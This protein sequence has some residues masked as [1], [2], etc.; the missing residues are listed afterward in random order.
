MC[1]NNSK[2]ISVIKCSNS[3]FLVNHLKRGFLFSRE[4]SK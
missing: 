2:K 3:L 4:K 1:G